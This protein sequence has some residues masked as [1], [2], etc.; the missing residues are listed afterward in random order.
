MWVWNILFILVSR[1]R[2]WSVLQVV[3][4]HPVLI[5]NKLTSILNKIKALIGMGL[6]YK[7]KNYWKKY[8]EKIGDCF[9]FYVIINICLSRK[10]SI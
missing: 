4:D 6:V 2:K 9:F 5:L 7:K 1:I 8:L 10:F 3:T